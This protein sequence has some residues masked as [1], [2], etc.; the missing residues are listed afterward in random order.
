MS[1]PPADA[2]ITVDIAPSAQQMIDEADEHWVAEHGYLV[3]NPLLDEIRNAGDLLRDN[4]QLGLL[5][6]RG[7]FRY[8]TRSLLLNSGWRLYYRFYAQR[9]R[10]EIVAVWFGSR[11]SEPPL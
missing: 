9:R 11:G 3:D 10:I 8:E 1:G 7:V 5:V 4:P 6:R 2:P